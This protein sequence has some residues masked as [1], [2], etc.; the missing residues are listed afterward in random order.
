MREKET[1]GQA[2]GDE[3]KEMPDY[4]RASLFYPFRVIVAFHINIHYI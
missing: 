3:K 4:N 2:G 1:P